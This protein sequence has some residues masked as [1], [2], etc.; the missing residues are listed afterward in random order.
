MKKNILAIELL[1]K[2]EALG[3]GEFWGG[4]AVGVGVVGAGFLIL[5]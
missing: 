5:T 3:C 1:E 2:V 4:V